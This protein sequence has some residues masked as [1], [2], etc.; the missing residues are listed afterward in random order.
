MQYIDRTDGSGCFKCERFCKLAIEKDSDIRPFLI[1]TFNAL[2]KYANIHA[3]LY[4][5]GTKSKN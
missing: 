4:I 2:V 1:K 5:T 3:A